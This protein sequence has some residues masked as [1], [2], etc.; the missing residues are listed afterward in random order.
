[1]Q[2]S[3]AVARKRARGQPITCGHCPGN[4][5]WGFAMQRGIM[6]GRG[7]KGGGWGRERGRDW[8]AQPLLEAT[9]EGSTA[10]SALC[11]EADDAIQTYHVPLQFGTFA[12][13]AKLPPNEMQCV[14]PLHSVEPAE[15]FPWCA[16]Q[17]GCDSLSL[18]I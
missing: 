3:G 6:Q 4:C 13:G 1:M 17:K 5:V 18:S 11:R 2:G 12:I 14:Q 16:L 10:G 8:Q 9:Q 7:G 15:H